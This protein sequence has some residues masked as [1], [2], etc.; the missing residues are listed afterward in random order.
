MTRT[1]ITVR[2]FESFEDAEFLRFEVDALNR[3]SAHPD[4]F[5]T[6]AFFEAY[7]RH[8]ELH[9]PGRGSCLW[10]L[11]AFRGP[12]LIG[13]LA[14]RQ[15]T[16]KVLVVSFNSPRM[17]RPNQTTWV[18]IPSQMNRPANGSNPISRNAPESP[19]ISRKRSFR[20]D[21]ANASSISSSTNTEYERVSR[22]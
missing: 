10:F 7:F 19:T 2:C 6:F 11:T 9:P 3:A 15:V 20:P 14:L 8:D 16:H 21:T 13:Y 12:Q 22:R 18:M 4:P 17:P 1:S 5:S